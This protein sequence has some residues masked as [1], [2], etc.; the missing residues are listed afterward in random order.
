MKGA[1]AAEVG[2]FTTKLY[3]RYDLDLI[4]IIKTVDGRRWVPEEKCWTIP[5]SRLKMLAYLLRGR[6][7]D[8]VTD[9]DE[10]ESANSRPRESDWAE[11][12]LARC[13]PELADK[14]FRALTKVLHPDVGGSPT[15]MRDLNVARD[16]V[17]AK[18]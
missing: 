16:R 9:K 7:Y 2:R 15:L 17:F 18:A 14:V 3:F 8:L 10:D 13:D 11:Q 6:G 4:A 12:L 5:T 1:V